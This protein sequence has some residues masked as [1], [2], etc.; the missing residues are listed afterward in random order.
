MF[1]DDNFGLHR[2]ATRELFRHMIPLRRSWVGQGSVS[3]AEDLELLSLMRRSGCTGLLIGFETV[4]EASQS[5]MAKLRALKISYFEAVRRFHGEG[6]MVL[7]AFVFGF[8]EDDRDTFDRTLEFA[9]SARLDLVQFRHLAPYPGTR[10]YNRLLREGRLVVPDWWLRGLKPNVL[11]FRPA[12]MSP[13]EFE[14]GLRRI[15]RQ[16]YSAGGIAGRFFG[17]KPWK[18]DLVSVATYLGA[19][20]GIRRR[21]L[22]E[23]EARHGPEVERRCA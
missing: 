19:N 1:V 21:Y 3:L 15:K 23:L 10:L 8:D 4:H 16:F 20:L 17:V 2:S 9:M 7:G 18:R 22:G 13:G 5:G 12:R 6:I 14:D 11:L